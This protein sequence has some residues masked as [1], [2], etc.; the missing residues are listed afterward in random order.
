VAP[1]FDIKPAGPL[2]VEAIDYF[3]AKHLLPSFSFEDVW[4]EEH[5]VAFTVAKAMNQDVLSTIQKAL[6]TALR[7][8]QTLQ[9]FKKDLTPTL[10]KLGWWGAKEMVDPKT[11]ET[12]E[13][14][15]GSP[16][17]LKTIFDANLRTARAAGQW[18]R[19]DRTKAV[20]GY[21]VYELG[22]SEH[23]RPLHEQWAGTILPVDDPWWDTHFTPNGWGCKC[24]VRQ[25]GRAELARL[26][27]VKH[28]PPTTFVK[29]RNSRTGQV[30]EVPAGIDPGWDFNPGKI[31][32][33]G[34]SK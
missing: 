21:L 30:L 3:D 13:A 25:I 10:Q 24:F 15:L 12:V 6:S 18:E 19:I 16:G 29:Y 23:H 8:G 17:R 5:A 1:A 2:P 27:G 11:G 9:Q 34:L 31:R 14:Q 4:R 28:P 7:E 32:L 22:P 26:G 33:G 20:R